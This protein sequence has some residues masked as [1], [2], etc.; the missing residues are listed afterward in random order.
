MMKGGVQL[1]VDICLCV[2]FC[3]SV[4]GDAP[5]VLVITV[6]GSGDKNALGYLVLQ[7]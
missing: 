3:V 4:C 7:A 5:I 6:K 1:P 2:C